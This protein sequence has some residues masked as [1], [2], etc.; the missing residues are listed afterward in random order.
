[1]PL[2]TAEE[3]VMFRG[4]VFEIVNLGIES[5]EE[6]HRRIVPSVKNSNQ[7]F[8]IFL[9]QEGIGLL[10]QYNE[11]TDPYVDFIGK[12]SE[13]RI[14]PIIFKSGVEWSKYSNTVDINGFVRALGPMLRDA[15]VATRNKMAIDYVM[16]GFS[17]G[18]SI[19]P[20]GK[21]LF[22]SDHP[23]G[24]GQ[25]QSNTATSALDYSS[26]M[27]GMIAIAR[28]RGR[29][30]V[31]RSDVGKLDLVFGPANIDAAQVAVRSTKGRPGTSDGDAH[32]H[33]ND[34]ISSLIKDNWLDFDAATRGA[35]FLKPASAEKN[36]L[37]YL[38]LQEVK[39]ADDVNE[40]RGIYGLFIDFWGAYFAMSH[41]GVYGSL[42]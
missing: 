8:E 5:Q 38:Q 25:T 15:A 11:G 6:T 27:T 28:Q 23:A 18:T 20:G 10:P 4:N 35:W 41:Y 16:A 31:P 13:V 33:L 29:R 26:A 37:A 32:E 36:P 17:G 12:V 24:A 21:T 34:S 1:M 3:S 14:D 40:K 7:L 22:A 9:A 19:V 39:T 2:V 42:V 30:G